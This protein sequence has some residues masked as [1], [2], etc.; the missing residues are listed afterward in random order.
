VDAC[1][2][3]ILLSALNDKF[4]RRNFWHYEHML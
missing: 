4:S 1:P 3:H 2:R